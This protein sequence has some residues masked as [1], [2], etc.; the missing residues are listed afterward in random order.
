MSVYNNVNVHTDKGGKKERQR[1]G[2]HVD[3]IP[4][5]GPQV[6]FFM[7]TFEVPAPIE[8]QSSPSGK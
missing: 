1:D 7:S 8:I 4:W 2:S 3:L 6:I 5:P